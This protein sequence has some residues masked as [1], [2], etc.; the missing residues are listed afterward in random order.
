MLKLGS[1][2]DFCQ[3]AAAQFAEQTMSAPLLTGSS[4]LLV[5]DEPLLRRQLAAYLERQ[6]AE[7]TAVTDLAAAR[8]MIA[9]MPCDFALVDVNLPDGVGTDLLREGAFSANTGVVVMTAEGGV[10]GAVE[11]MKL[12]ALNYL[13]KPFEPAEL[14]LVFNAVRRDRSARRLEQ[15]R[16]EDDTLPETEFFFGTGLV[17]LRSQLDRILA[18]DRRMQGRL[19]PVLVLGETG[20]GK[21]TI[22]RWLHQRGPRGEKP[23]VEVNCPALPDTLAESEL[24]GHE[25]GAFTDARS[26]RI[27]LFEAAD[28]GTL[29]LDE[30][31]SLSLP[32]QSK[33]LTVIEDGRIRRVGANKTVSVDVRLVAASNRDL[34][35]LV[36]AGQF[37]EDL[38]HRLD[39]FRLRIPPL[40][41]RVEDIG[42]LAETLLKRICRRQRLELRPIT[43]E[44]RCRLEG[45]PWPGNVRELA[46]EIE[47]AVVFEDGPL[48]F[49]HLQRLSGGVPV[50]VGGGGD[51]EWFNAGYRFPERGFSLEQ[52]IDRLVQHAVEQAGSV[53]GGGVVG[54]VAFFVG[55]LAAW[56]GGG[57]RE[58]R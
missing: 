56:V 54:C 7:V 39:L 40:R 14:L 21:T 45:W 34:K 46:H 2:A 17:E 47:R 28:G 4:V 43:E 55:L 50:T 37:R 9:S 38:Y 8:Q 18:A 49:R 29:F 35:E 12:G 36:A 16:R 6:G 3:G 32:L 22:A 15:H 42:P 13:T 11:A 1:A 41:E 58:G 33:V 19:A 23:C 24:F 51:G 52:A 57:G 26:A 25:R 44:G 10:G 31:A 53:G 20:S 30:L 27:G 5:E 48:E